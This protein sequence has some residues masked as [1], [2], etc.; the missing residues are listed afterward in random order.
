MPG[1]D[2]I[3]LQ[4]DQTAALAGHSAGCRRVGGLMLRQEVV[5]RE[6]LLTLEALVDAATETANQAFLAPAL[7]T[8]RW[9]RWLWGQLLG[10][11][12]VAHGF[13]ELSA[14]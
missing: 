5:T 7:L 3:A 1:T 6:D 4:T 14:L 9:R 8:L 10:H 11:K 13:Q 12:L 2:N